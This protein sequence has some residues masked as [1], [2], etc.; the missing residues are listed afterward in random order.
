MFCTK[1]AEVDDLK[2]IVKP[3]GR[4]PGGYFCLKDYMEEAKVF[5]SNSHY[6]LIVNLA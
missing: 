1:K 6:Y 3:S 2:G 4:H 5:F